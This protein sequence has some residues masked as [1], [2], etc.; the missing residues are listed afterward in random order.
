MNPVTG[1]LRLAL[2]TVDQ[3][4]YCSLSGWVISSGL[5]SESVQVF[6]CSS[7]PVFAV[8]WSRNTDRTGALPAVRAV[9]AAQR[10]PRHRG[11]Q[12]VGR[13]VPAQLPLV[14]LRLPTPAGRDV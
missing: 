12:R 4:G 9:P 6:D 14:A 11:T 3:L 8:N 7:G 2:E 10:Q 13:V 5:Y 1:A